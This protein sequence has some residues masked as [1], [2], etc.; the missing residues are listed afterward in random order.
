MIFDI[1][2]LIPQVFKVYKQG[3][4]SYR[5]YYI[6]VYK[7]IKTIHPFLFKKDEHEWHFTYYHP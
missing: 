4:K 5:L 1:C 3:L 2:S 6:N 7:K